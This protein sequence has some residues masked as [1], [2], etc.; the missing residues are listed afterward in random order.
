[1]FLFSVCFA[2][3]T[4]NKRKHYQYVKFSGTNWLA[5]SCSICCEQGKSFMIF[6]SRMLVLRSSQKYHFLNEKEKINKILKKNILRSLLVYV[7]NQLNRQQDRENYKYLLCVDLCN[8][9]CLKGAVTSM[10][11]ALAIDEAKCGVRVNR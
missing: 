8:F 1:M 10:T 7:C 3:L 6:S 5:W 4:E 11:K 2:S 9:V